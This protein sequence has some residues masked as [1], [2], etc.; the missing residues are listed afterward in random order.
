MREL[1]NNPD[2]KC[3]W[4]DPCTKFVILTAERDLAELKSD[5]G[6]CGVAPNTL[7]AVVR[8]PEEV[9]LLHGVVVPVLPAEVA[10]SQRVASGPVVMLVRGVGGP[11]LTGLAAQSDAGRSLVVH[12]PIPP[13]LALCVWGTDAERAISLGSGKWWGEDL[14]NK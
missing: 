7:C 10:G 11:G 5:I 12:P 13:V 8:V 1:S 9:L 6:I 14:I 3:S 2:I 4:I